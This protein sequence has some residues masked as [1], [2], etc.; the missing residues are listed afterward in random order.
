MFLYSTQVVDKGAPMK[1]KIIK[2]LPD[3]ELSV[4]QAVWSCEKE[5]TRQEIESHLGKDHNQALTTL[6]TELSRLAD[7]GFLKVTKNGRSNLYRPLVA[8][9]EY[10]AAQSKSFVENLCGGNMSVFANALCDSGISK[11]DLA[12]LTA[13]L[14]EKS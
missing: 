11:E 9:D 14:Q 10:L 5:A 7:K 6:L 1:K 2:K 8:R 4:M 12:E 13:L 3:A